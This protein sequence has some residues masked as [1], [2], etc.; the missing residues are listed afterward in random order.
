MRRG[1]FNQAALLAREVGRR[2]AVGYEPLLLTRHG[3]T[4]HQ[5]GFS[6]DERAR[7]LQGAF[8][9]PQADRPAT[10]G[11]RIVLVDDAVTLRATGQ[12]GARCLLRA[13]AANVDIQMFARVATPIE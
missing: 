13:G 7:N 8:A 4:K 1:R 9:L 3:S 10:R 2:S 11:K 6:R 5:V 12:A